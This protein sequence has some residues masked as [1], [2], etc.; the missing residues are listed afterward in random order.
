MVSAVLTLSHWKTYLAYRHGKS[1]SCFPLKYFIVMVETEQQTFHWA[2]A[3]TRPSRIS[4]EDSIKIIPVG[5]L[6]DRR[7]IQEEPGP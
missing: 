7:C 3:V 5:W 6:K 4:S 1:F 2:N